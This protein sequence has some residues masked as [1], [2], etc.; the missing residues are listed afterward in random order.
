LPTAHL[1][2]TNEVELPLLH[3]RSFD[4]Y[5]QWSG[6][7]PSDLV[8][9]IWQEPH[10][11]FADA[12]KLQDKLRSTVAR[13]DHPAGVFTWKY[14]NWGNARR[15]IRKS[16]SQ[17]PARKAWL[18]S[19]FLQASGIA[20]PLARAYIERRWGPFQNCS[21]LLTDYVAGTSLYRLM[22]FERPSPA[23]VL[24]LAE[25]V[26][27]IWQQLDDLCVWHNDFKTENLLVDPQ[28]KVWLIDLERMRCFDDRRRLRQRQIKDARDLLHPRNWR[29]EPSA[30]EIFRQAI[31]AS[32]A[33]REILAGRDAA[34]HPLGRTLPSD[35]CPQQLVTVLIPCRNAADT[36]LSCLESVRDMA[37]EILVAD[38]GSTDDTL[39]LVREFG[40]CRVIER[41]G[42]DE[43]ALAE[44]AHRQARHE[45]ILLLR[46]DEQLNAELSRQVQD[47]LATEPEQ[48]GFFIGRTIYFRGRRLR[49]GSF[50]EDFSIR[51]YRT[52]AGR[53]QLREGR[54]EVCVP[55]QRVGRVKSRLIHEACPSIEKCLREMMRVANRAAEVAQQNGRHAS[56]RAVLWTAPWRFLQSYVLRGGFLDGWAGLVASGLLALET[57]LREAMHWQLERPFLAR[58]SLIHDQWGELKV[59]DPT[60][61]PDADIS[62]ARP[63]RTAA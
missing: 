8:E 26:A 58:R 48:D 45:W 30:A 3:R 18:D 28:G 12:P 60:A 17:S 31:A 1:A 52:Q 59:F 42:A 35:N 38:A 53:F 49:H 43:V 56:R 33:G 37:D 51:L 25:Q 21:Y 29:S 36:I 20:T 19:R 27:A 4:R 13:I 9:R 22:R 63:V 44:W 62:D 32:P 47:L 34:K 7:L 24:H 14:H 61:D 15:A 11:L 41:D 16:L 54:L 50:Q 6:D 40:G 10:A 23:V 46:P 2:R 39:R 55:S 57:Y 5:M